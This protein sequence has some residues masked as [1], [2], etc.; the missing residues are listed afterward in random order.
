V[1][2]WSGWG[3]SIRRKPPD[4]WKNN[5]NWFLHHD[6]APA[7]TSLVVRQFLTSKNI[8]VIPHPSPYLPD[9]APCDVFLFPKIKLRLKGCRFDTT[10]EIHAESQ[11]VINTLTFEN[12]QGFTKSWKTRWNRCIVYMPKGTTTKET[13]ETRSYGSKLFLWS[14]SP[15]FWVAPRIYFSFN[16]SEWSSLLYKFRTSRTWL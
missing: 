5:N 3:E 11:E 6:N 2:F 12:L 9:L 10:E 1:R 7:H 15:K 13:V 16:F 4:N 8:T 14:N